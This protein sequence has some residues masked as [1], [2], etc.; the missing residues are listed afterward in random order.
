MG[1]GAVVNNQML[2]G[3]GGKRGGVNEV[4]L[5]FA[6]GLTKEVWK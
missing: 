6:F 2:L 5:T 3:K 1:V 4:H